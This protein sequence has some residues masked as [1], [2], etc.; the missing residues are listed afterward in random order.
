MV[1]WGVNPP[2]PLINCLAAILLLILF[3]IISLAQIWRRLTKQEILILLILLK[4]MVL[5]TAPAF[6]KTALVIPLPLLKI[7]ILGILVIQLLLLKL[8]Q[9]IKPLLTNKATI[10]PLL[11]IKAVIATLQVL[12]RPPVH[13][14]VQVLPRPMAHITAQVL[15]KAE[16]LTRLLLFKA[17]VTKVLPWTKK[18]TTVPPLLI[19][20]VVTIA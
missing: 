17:V 1:I 12:V 14:I 2:Q 16:C 5:V 6:P 9:A 20:T 15:P 7:R 3:N 10:V 19:K 18:M 13:I 8:T 11:L 4:V